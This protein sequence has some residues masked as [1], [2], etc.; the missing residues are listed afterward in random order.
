MVFSNSDTAR[1]KFIECNKFLA[2]LICSS[3]AEGLEILAVLFEMSL[4][5]EIVSQIGMRIS[6]KFYL[7]PCE[8]IG[9]ISKYLLSKHF[10]H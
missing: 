6:S 5:G 4:L 8:H 10:P 3:C 9:H 7:I 2:R 1:L